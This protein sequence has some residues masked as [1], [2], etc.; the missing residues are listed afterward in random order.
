MFSFCPA[1]GREMLFKGMRS[2]PVPPP[3]H[4]PQAHLA[5]R[6][7]LLGSILTPTYLGRT[8][9]Q[10]GS[11]LSGSMMESTLL[12]CRSVGTRRAAA[13]HTLIRLPWKEHWFGAGRRS[14]VLPLWVCVCL[15]VCLCV[16]V[17]VIFHHE[18]PSTCTERCIFHR[19]HRKL[20]ISCLFTADLTPGDVG[21]RFS[22]VAGSP[23][24]RRIRSHS[25]WI[26]P[27]QL[28]LSVFN[29]SRSLVWYSCQSRN[30]TLRENWFKTGFFR[31]CSLKVNNLYF[32]PLVDWNSFF[33]WVQMLL[34]KFIGPNTW[35]KMFVHR[36]PDP[37]W[38]SENNLIWKS[39]WLLEIYC[40]QKSVVTFP[41]CCWQVSENSL[42]RINRPRGWSQTI[43]CSEN[44]FREK[45]GLMFILWLLSLVHVPAT[46]ME[47]NTAPCHQGAVETL[48]LHLWMFEIYC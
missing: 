6:L 2:R 22:S 39:L 37:V 9:A 23:I 30:K 5:F 40:Q 44:G 43:V 33:F 46:N 17:C 19:L 27:S 21:T 8:D 4:I 38:V 31:F 12:I 25:L 47:D 48:W 32:L 3:Q 34:Y 7:E 15:F 41:A 42:S 10:N 16:C 24:S 26:R 36:Q 35:R 13:K 11:P 45:N 1:G 18:N 28:C 20:I 29:L 14:D